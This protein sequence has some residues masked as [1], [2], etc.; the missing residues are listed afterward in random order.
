MLGAVQPPDEKSV[1]VSQAF[2]IY[3][4]EIVFS[5]LFNKSEEQ[6][7]AWT[8]TKQTSIDYFITQI[9]DMKMSDI[10]RSHALN[11]KKWWMSRMSLSEEN[12]KPVKPNTANRHVG[13]MRQLYKEY[14][15]HIGQEERQNPFRNIYFKGD[16]KSRVQSFDNEW[17]QQKI[18][19]PGLF[20]TL[21]PEL[22]GLIYVLIETGA[23]MSEIVNLMPADIKLDEPVPYISIKPRERRQLK[24]PDS[25]RDI[26]L[27]GVA[28]EAMQTLPSGF[29]KY[30]EKG[31]LVSANLMKAFIDT[32]K[33]P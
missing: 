20:D 15:T 33:L 1:T 8:K 14:Y 10:E 22:K 25:E 4:K 11:Y 9:S 2:E 27:V 21:N 6:R 23:R 17:I 29:P 30:R 3:L 28:L 24:T 13:N 16:V 18:L 31:A 19:V 5:E 32:M 12:K 7:R 26:P